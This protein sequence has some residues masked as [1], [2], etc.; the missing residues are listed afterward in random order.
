MLKNEVLNIRN[1]LCPKPWIDPVRGEGS[2]VRGGGGLN[3]G[4]SQNKERKTEILVSH[5][6]RAKTRRG[7]ETAVCREVA[8]WCFPAGGGCSPG[9]DTP[10]QSVPRSHWWDSYNSLQRAR[11]PPLRRLERCQTPL[12]HLHSGRL[13]QMDCALDHSRLASV[14][15][16]R[17]QTSALATRLSALATGVSVLPTDLSV[18]A[19]PPSVSALCESE[20]D[21][22]VCYHSCSMNYLHCLEC[23][24]VGE[25]YCLSL[26]GEPYSLSARTWWIPLRN[27]CSIDLHWRELKGHSLQD[28]TT[29]TSAP[30]VGALS[31]LDWRSVCCTIRSNS[32]TMK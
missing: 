24:E 5:K 3:W 11:S 6:S 32:D 19:T 14:A 21:P 2:G 18:R 8:R 16:L 31:M 27:R 15:S 4:G 1:S 23:V 25:V 7:Q 28:N 9:C 10:L 29:N 26:I 17:A 20:C 13:T 22:L 30:F 12:V